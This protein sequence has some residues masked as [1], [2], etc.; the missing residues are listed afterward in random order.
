MVMND[1]IHKIRER[2]KSQLQTIVLPESQDARIREAAEIIEK[3]GIARVLLLEP[4]RIDVEKKEKYSRE[5]FRL[6]QKKGITLEEAREIISDPLY[7]AAMMVRD[8]SADGFVAGAFYT[9]PEVARAAIRCFNLN[10]QIIV[11]SS[12]FIMVLPDTTWGEKGVFVFADCGIVPHPNSEQL[13]CIAISAAEL[14]REVLE[15]EPRIALLSYSTKGSGRGGAVREVK[16]A[17][18]LIRQKNPELLVDGELQVDAAIVPEVA[19]I[20]KADVILEGR[21]NVLI[22]PN[23]N[24]GNI[25][26]KL[27]Q[28]LAN[29]RAIGP[30]ILGLNRPCSDLSRGCSIE[31]IID[32]IAVTAIRAH[33]Q[34]QFGDG[35]L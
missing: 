12:C 10:P 21:A 17:V 6:R 30:L 29:A 20:K 34:Q 35:S 5:F 22:F 15:I 31:D 26:Y 7:Y 14:T 33:S 4:G 19:R 18:E 24:A 23:L 16:L 25:S 32:C 2:A 8:K 11:A 3:E 1:I 27:V 13:A 9:T 28:R